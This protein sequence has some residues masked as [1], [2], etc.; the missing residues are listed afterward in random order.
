MKETRPILYVAF[1]HECLIFTD[2]QILKAF[3]GSTTFFLFI[4]SLSISGQYFYKLLFVSLLQIFLLMLVFAVNKIPFIEPIY[5][6]CITF[7]P[8]GNCL[9]SG[10]HDSLKVHGW[11]PPKVHDMLMMGWGK[12]RDIAI[13]SSQLVGVMT[14]QPTNSEMYYSKTTTSE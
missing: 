14:S 13:S 11:E 4:R 1:D 8:E 2:E 9:F 10:S 5:F 12:I 7:H 6:R 3:V